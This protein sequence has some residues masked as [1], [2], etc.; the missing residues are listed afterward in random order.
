MSCINDDNHRRV[1]HYAAYV[2]HIYIRKIIPLPCQMNL[3]AESPYRNYLG[4]GAAQC[5]RKAQQ[6]CN[7]TM[8]KATESQCQFSG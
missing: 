7:L 3:L 8:S 1:I 2:N 6:D 4:H 5:Y